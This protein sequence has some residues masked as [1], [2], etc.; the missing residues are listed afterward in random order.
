MAS[1]PSI[2]VSIFGDVSNNLPRDAIQRNDLE[3][4]SHIVE[5][6]AAHTN[7]ANASRNELA[8]E[9]AA[10]ATLQ[11]KLTTRF[12]SEEIADITRAYTMA[13]DAHQ[14]QTR[15]SGEP[16]IVHPIAVADIVFDMQLDHISVMAALLHD[17]LEDTKASRA[18]LVD[19]F[20]DELAAI[21]DGLSKLNHL[22]FKSKAEAQAASLRKMLLAMVKD[23]RVILIKLADRLHNMR[24]IGA[25]RPDKQRR[26][27]RETLEVYAP[28]ANRLGMYS[29]KNELEDLGFRSR[30][31]MRSRIL[32]TTVDKARRNRDHV[33]GRIEER[34]SAS[35]SEQG[36]EAIVLASRSMTCLPCVSWSIL[37]MNVT[38]FWASCIGSM[39]LVSGGLKTT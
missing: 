27:G 9:L 11:D 36:I 15:R 16:Y 22:D 34:I 21:V 28:I 32:A 3:P 10:F 18:D 19:A 30:Y 26:I 35:L 39:Y 37:K 14:S 29:I 8:P 5:S 24:T 6:L 31:P 7:S 1:P 23:L 33:I 4:A 12:N 2:S 13:R 25:L 20:G 38:E 17:V